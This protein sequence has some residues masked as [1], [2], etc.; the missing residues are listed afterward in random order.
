MN[1]KRELLEL[2]GT[3]CNGEITAS[4]VSQLEQLLD[5]DTAAQQIYRQYMAMHAELLWQQSALGEFPVTTPGV[6]PT[7]RAETNARHWQFN[8]QQLGWPLALAACLLIGLAIG[9]QGS[10]T[11]RAGGVPHRCRRRREP[12]SQVDSRLEA[13]G[14][15]GRRPAGPTRIERPLF[16]R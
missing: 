3:L 11:D 15:A 14:S 12:G 1:K 4:E 2:V 16:I 10:S 13:N 7:E 6:L 8:W 5:G 9:F